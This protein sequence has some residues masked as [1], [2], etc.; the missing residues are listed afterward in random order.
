M[1]QPM[2]PRKTCVLGD[3][4]IVCEFSFV[5]HERTADGKEIIHKFY[6]SKLKLN[7]ERIECIKKVTERS[8]VQECDGGYAE[9]ASDQL[10]LSL[11]LMR[12]TKLQNKKSGKAWIL[13]I[14]HRLYP[15]PLPDGLLL[16][17]ECYVQIPLIQVVLAVDRQTPLPKCRLSH[18]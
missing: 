13:Y 4:C 2:T 18:L 8:D 12:K 5:Q 9:N 16:L 3:S 17:S 10:S 15:F 6:Q 7:S 14:E 11:K 1:A